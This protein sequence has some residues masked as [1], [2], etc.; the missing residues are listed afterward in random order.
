MKARRG[1]LVVVASL[2]ISTA[3][4]LGAGPAVARTAKVKPAISCTLTGVATVTPG[5]STTLAVQTIS[6]TSSLSS[7]TGSSVPG[8]TASSGSSTTSST[9]KK[10]S[11]CASAA[12]KPSVSKVPF[13]TI[14]WNNA[15]SSTDKYKTTLKL[16]QPATLKG[17]ILSGT[18]DKGKVT[19]SLTYTY[20]PGQNCVSTPI[21]SATITGTFTIT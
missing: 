19:A 1:T 12:G 9:G 14:N 4:V 18:F 2:L 8:I 15:T 20:G 11:N 17:K 10:P 5:L 7:C 13:G 3:T 6:V 16:G 21:T